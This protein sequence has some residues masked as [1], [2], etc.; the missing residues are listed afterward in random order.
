VSTE[1]AAT[2]EALSTR[3]MRAWMEADR[4]TLEA[5]LAPDYALIVSSLP[6]RL[7][8][9]H[10]WLQTCE[11]YSCS[12]F[13]YRDVQVRDFG[14]IAI[15]SSIAEQTA[16]LDGAD[17]SGAF[18]LTDVWR[19]AGPLG[20]QVFARHSSHPEAASASTAAMGALSG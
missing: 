2:I 11:R 18:F 17:R 16:S 13:A 1:L 8:D 14:E 12:A 5:L 10:T 9:R 6:G 4:P 15:M 7:I 19:R 20:W 3:W